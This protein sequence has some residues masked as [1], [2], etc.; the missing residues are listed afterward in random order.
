M[1]ITRYGV[2]SLEK[3]EALT[4]LLGQKPSRCTGNC[5][6]GGGGGTFLWK[7]AEPSAVLLAAG[8]GGGASYASE[9]QQY[10][11]ADA[12]STTDG[13]FCRRGEEFSGPVGTGGT[14]GGQ[15]AGTGANSPYHGG[16]GGGWDE[17]G[18]CTFYRQTC[19]SGRSTAHLG[20]SP[21]ADAFARGGF[22]GGGAGGR[23]G[24]GGGGYSGGSGGR[25]THCGGGGGGS[26][27]TGII[28]GSGGG[29]H[30]GGGKLVVKKLPFN[31]D[32]LYFTPCGQKGRT[33][34]S[35]DMCDE[36]YDHEKNMKGLVVEN[37]VQ[38]I[39]IPQG[40]Q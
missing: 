33:G 24:G 37:G 27:S 25:E 23:Q 26:L 5:G 9:N 11:G 7:D 40:G 39:T 2:F 8:G 1:C 29:L 32:A 19:G 22:G 4:A 21:A 20:G 10:W 3:D 31:E 17:A 30:Q 28:H 36:A 14:G 34:P 16:G 18:K 15:W 12:S 6:G 38:T 35:Q 13:T